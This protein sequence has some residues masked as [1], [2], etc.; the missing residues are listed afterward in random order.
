MLSTNCFKSG[1]FLL[2]VIKI[3]VHVCQVRNKFL[4]T[5]NFFLISMDILYVILMLLNY[6]QIVL[7]GLSVNLMHLDGTQSN[8]INISIAAL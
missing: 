2:I 3:I 5:I 7:Y 8:K 6:L 1:I 4:F